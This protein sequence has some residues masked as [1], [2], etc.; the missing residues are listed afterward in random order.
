[1]TI[2]IANRLQQ[3]RKQNGYSQEDLANKIGVSRQAISKWERAEASP[4]TDNLLL[5]AKLY[6]VSID[7]LLR[8]DESIMNLNSDVADNSA[9]ETSQTSS[10]LPKIS[11]TKEDYA[12]E[13]FPKD[14]FTDIEIY[15]QGNA[16]SAP[17]GSPFSNDEVYN[18]NIASET[19]KN[20]FTTAKE[21]TAETNSEKYNSQNTNNAGYS[22]SASTADTANNN[23]SSTNNKSCN[24]DF[25]QVGQEIGKG[26]GIVGQEIGKGLSYAGKEINKQIKLAK[27]AEK[28]KQSQQTSAGQSADNSQNGYNYNYSYN[29]S[30]NNGT[31]TQSEQCNSSCCHNQRHIEK[32]KR[33]E[34]KRRMKS[35]Y[36]QAYKNSPAYKFPYPLLVAIAYVAVGVMFNLW[37]PAWLLFLTIP[38]YYTGIAAKVH[39]NAAYFCYPVFITLVY[40]CLGFLFPSVWGWSWILFLTIPLY[41]CF[42][43]RKGSNK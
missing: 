31:Q 12:R 38:M 19:P 37:H 30:Y 39:G 27:E 35:Q 1:M 26:I 28:Q 25:E 23:T 8:T 34:E 7:Q 21:Y 24:I 15:P 16:N 2:E 32:M 17:Q 4:D 42:F 36:K 33:K 18:K 3:L 41:Y 5:L 29:Y 43:G 22:S 10:T 20:D 14:N 11:L 9:N 40:L 13:V 6:N